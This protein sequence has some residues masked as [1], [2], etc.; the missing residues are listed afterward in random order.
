MPKVLITTARIRPNRAEA[1]Q[2]IAVALTAETESIVKES[3]IINFLIDEAA[4]H[5][6]S[7]NG[8]LILK[9]KSKAKRRTA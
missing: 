6:A 9:L 5:V 4:Q 7:H 3:D 1:L 8:E 2:K